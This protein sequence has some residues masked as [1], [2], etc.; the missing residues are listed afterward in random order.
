[1][2]VLIW[3]EEEGVLINHIRSGRHVFLSAEEMRPEA[4]LLDRELDLLLDDALNQIEEYANEKK[5]TPLLKS[6]SIGRAVARSG[7]QYHKAMH[8][9]KREM[10]WEALAHKCWYGVRADTSRD[11]L[12]RGLRDTSNKGKRRV[13]PKKSQGNANR[14]QDFEIGLWLS[15][16]EFKEAGQVFGD[17]ISNAYDLYRRPTLKSHELRKAIYCW[18]QRQAEEVKF[19][20][21]KAKPG[22]GGFSIIAKAL[23]HRFPSRGPGSTLL[24]QH[25]EPD[26]L[27]AIVN[28]VLDAARDTHFPAKSE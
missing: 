16:Q 2:A 12:W 15:D 11:F 7:V 5:A 28:D 9:E 14:Y 22:T 6:W 25:Y 23:V 8:E 3:R 13:N 18:L 19:E 21:R 27:Q 4:E 17:Y 10:L 24:P 26:E 1:M 20:L